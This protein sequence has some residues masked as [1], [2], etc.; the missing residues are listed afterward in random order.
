MRKK[1]DFPMSV[2]WRADQQIHVI[3]TAQ[4]DLRWSLLFLLITLICFVVGWN[5]RADHPVTNNCIDCH[6]PRQETNLIVFDW[7][8]TTE[9]PEMRNHWIKVYPVVKAAVSP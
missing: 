3:Q 5:T 2:L 9:R 7:K 6:M 1:N 8:G 4:K